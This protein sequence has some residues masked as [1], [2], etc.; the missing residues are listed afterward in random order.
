MEN[1]TQHLLY[2]LVARARNGSFGKVSKA[3]E[4]GG[5]QRLLTVKTLSIVRESSGNDVSAVLNH[6]VELLFQMKGFNHPNTAKLLDVSAAPIN[7]R[8]NLTLVSE[9]VKEDLSAY[10]AKIPASGLTH[11]TIKD[12]MLQLLRGLEFLHTYGVIHHYL[13]PENILV[14]SR[15]EIKIAD[16]GLARIHK[17]DIGHSCVQVVMMW[18]QA[19]EVLLTSTCT[20]TVDMWSVGCIFA[21]L[22]LLKVIGFPSE[23][24]WPQNSSIPY[25]SMKGPKEP[26]TQLLPNLSQM[27]NDLL[28]KCLEFTASTRISASEALVHPFL[29]EH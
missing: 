5:H 11:D 9:Y 24:D 16:F 7:G 17:L 21:E 4:I 6:E 20:S 19:P 26:F 12:M 22:F 3:R 1:N 8:L 18:Y 29:T 13:N 10:L 15:G 28:S 25:S 2:K 23:K 14:N 27:E